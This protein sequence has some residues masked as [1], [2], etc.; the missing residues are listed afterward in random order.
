MKKLKMKEAVSKEAY[1]C[2][3]AA[4]RRIMLKW[5]QV[6]ECSGLGRYPKTCEEVGK[7]IPEDWI[8]KY[9]AEHIGEVMAMLNS[10]YEDGR[11]R[12]WAEEEYH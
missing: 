5:A 1:K 9:S 10:V 3:T 2:F 4:E 7:R 11:R 6:K 12:G 8:H